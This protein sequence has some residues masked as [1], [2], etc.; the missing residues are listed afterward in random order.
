M[1]VGVYIVVA[2][3]KEKLSF[4]RSVFVVVE[5]VER[6]SLT[7]VGVEVVEISALGVTAG[8]AVNFTRGR[9]ARAWDLA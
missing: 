5:R 4:R 2:W 3:E 1:N 8:S 6:G 9:R 7:A